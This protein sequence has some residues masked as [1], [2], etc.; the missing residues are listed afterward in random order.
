MKHP[1]LNKVLQVIK[2]EP[3]RDLI[4][5]ESRTELIDE[6]ESALADGEKMAKIREITKKH[7]SIGY[8]IECANSI[9]FAR[10][11]NA[12]LNSLAP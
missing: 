12:I 10:D 1:R 11:I 7:E 4:H 2:A 8:E 6:I 5:P 9:S 3:M